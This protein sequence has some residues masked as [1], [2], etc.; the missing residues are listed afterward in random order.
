MV[1][2]QRGTERAGVGYGTVWDTG[3]RRETGSYRVKCDGE[4]WELAVFDG[5]AKGKI[6]SLASS[7]CL[8]RVLRTLIHRQL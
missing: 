7:W 3:Q 5:W 1:P 6:D 8:A 4:G 2:S